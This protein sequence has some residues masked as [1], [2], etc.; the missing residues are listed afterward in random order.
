MSGGI[1]SE[2]IVS[3]GAHVIVYPNFFHRAS[4]QTTQKPLLIPINADVFFWKTP[5]MR[6]PIIISVLLS[7]SLRLMKEKTSWKAIKN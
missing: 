2:G 3:L 4:P 1:L 7:V 6:S 5:D